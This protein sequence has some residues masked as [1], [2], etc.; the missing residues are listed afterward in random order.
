MPRPRPGL[1][2]DEKGAV[3]PLF[4][5]GLVVFLG[6]GGLA[7][8][9]S[10]GLAL[11]GELDAAVDAAALAGATQLDGGAQA[12]AR[13]TT[14]ANG[15]VTNAQRLANTPQTNAT[16]AGQ[17]TLRFLS[18]LSPR[19]YT[20]TPSAAKFIEVDATP[21]TL[22]VVLRMA[23]RVTSFSARAHAVAGYGS[24]ICK[25]PPLMICNPEETVSDLDFD[26]DAYT[27]KSFILTPPPGGNSQW[28]PGNFGFLSVGN[29]ASA[30]KDAMGRNPPQT[31]CFG[32]VAETEPGNIASA[33]DWFNTRFDIYRASAS[34]EKNNPLFGPSL[35]TIIGSE[36]KASDACT[37]SVSAPPDSCANSN[38]EA[39][40]Y[41]MPKDC[42][43]GAARVG[44]GQWNV[45]KYFAT[46]HS[47]INPASYTPAIPG[48]PAFGGAG[49]AAYGPAA[50][51]G[52]ATPTRFQ[53]YNWELAIL[54]GAITKPAGAFSGSQDV[55][56]TGNTQRDVAR[57]QCNTTNP[58]PPA[59]DRRTISAVVVNCRAD[60]VRGRT[61]VN[62]I[63]YVDLFLTAPAVSATIY[64]E[65]IGATTDVSA[66]GKETRKYSVRLYE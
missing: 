53:V 52:A 13:A 1:V 31:E 33:D 38:A 54:S 29:G 40:G 3:A 30:I 7:W 46:N 11:R 63:A 15:L 60:N 44:T 10:R 25:V 32:T 26:A 23:S 66:V 61:N 39:N 58:S 22:G 47:G 55:L 5:I 56:S 12:I 20:T 64:G 17:V 57:P 28:G 2:A 4:A 48:S 59:P 27:G 34:G 9:V 21:R 36:V 65:F 51:G 16:A 18:S 41:G 42:N 45:G 35:N 6:M 14:A 43:Q 49:W 24:G 37:P 8:D 19:T 50:T 62:I